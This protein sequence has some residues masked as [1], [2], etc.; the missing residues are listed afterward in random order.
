MGKKAYQE[1]ELTWLE[2]PRI[3]LYGTHDVKETKN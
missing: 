2:F 1:F 3:A